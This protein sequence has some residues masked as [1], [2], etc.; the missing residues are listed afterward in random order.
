MIR[1]FV[2]EVCTAPG[3]GATITL[4]GAAPAGRR[5][6]ASAFVTSQPVVFYTLDDSIQQEWGI[7]Q[8]IVGAPS[9]IIRPATVMGNSAG[10]TARLN[11]TAATR[12]Y[13]AFPSDAAFG[14]LQDNTGRNLLHNSRMRVQQRGVGPFT[15]SGYGADR[16]DSSAVHGGGGS[17]SVQI[18]GF[19]DAQR[20]LLGDEEA[21]F[22]W[23]NAFTGGSA[24][25]DFDIVFQ[26]IEDV[27]RT[28]NKSVM[29]SF[30]AAATSGTPKLCVELTQNFGS[31][32]SPSAAVTGI[33]VS[34]V[35]LS[36]VWQ[37]YVVGP[38]AVPSIVGKTLG[39]TANTTFTSLNFWLSSGATFNASRAGSIGVQAATI[40]IS[41][42]QVEASN[43]PT[44]LEK[45]DIADD[46]ARC[47]RFYNTVS[48]FVGP[49]AS[50]VTTYSFPVKMRAAPT[51]AGGGAGYATQALDTNNVSHTQTT[52]A[53]QTLTFT[54]D[55]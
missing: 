16:W 11:F 29:V 50:Y 23:S 45:T 5:T 34:A 12:C 44:P 19:T 31:G 13:T 22:V 10:T 42:I 49:V 48:T 51:I 8:L 15:T 6:W 52:G 43:Y 30:W 33:G 53:T 25:G 21:A 18:I 28:A 35:T 2:L 40:G 47:Q 41:G 9:T 1:D 55:L 54:A 24:A 14:A 32:G 38:I 46:I 36:T 17:F 4:P 20:T 27:R 3:S 37:R 39:S 26:P 7:G